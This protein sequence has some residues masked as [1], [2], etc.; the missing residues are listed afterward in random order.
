M[1]TRLHIEPLRVEH[2][3]AL[4]VHIRHPA[5]YEHIGGVPSLEGFVL[6]RTRALRGPGQAAGGEIWLNFL[7][8]EQAS[9]AML[10]RIE[11]TVHDSIAEVAF[12]FDPSQWGRGYALEA[13]EWLHAEIR[14]CSGV[15][16]F[17]ATTVPANARC[18]SL[19]LRSGYERVSQGA[20]DLFSYDRGDLVFNRRTA[21]D[22]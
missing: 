16:D 14:R 17:W 18:Q 1:N 6:D 21:A 2:L 9:Q 11:A 19:L 5:V 8:R 13:L 22:R 12:L 20:P 7:V 3:E 10:G 4:A 15:N